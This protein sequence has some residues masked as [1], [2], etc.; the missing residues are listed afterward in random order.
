[1][2]EV[3]CRTI[4]NSDRNCLRLSNFYS[5]KVRLKK[6]F[7]KLKQYF[8]YRLSYELYKN[9]LFYADQSEK[10]AVMEELYAFISQSRYSTIKR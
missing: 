6:S 3:C 9:A 7:N 4:A 8:Q 1:M 2:W 10:E 5:E